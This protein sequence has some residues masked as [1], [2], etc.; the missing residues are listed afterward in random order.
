MRRYLAIS[1]ALLGLSCVYN[2]A[3]GW[4]WR[5]GRPSTMQSFWKVEPEQE[6]AFKLDI[7][8][9]QR[10]VSEF[11]GRTIYGDVDV[12]PGPGTARDLRSPYDPVKYG[13]IERCME[14]KGW[15]PK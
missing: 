8:E 11:E 6:A 3:T 5:G 12:G 15:V 4:G 10:S 2:S 13:H 1:L 7:R 9:C 14:E